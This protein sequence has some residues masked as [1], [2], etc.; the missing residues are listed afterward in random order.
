MK[1]TFKN[2]TIEADEI[3][4]EMKRALVRNYLIGQRFDSVDLNNIPVI[5][6]QEVDDLIAKEDELV[7]APLTAVEF[8]QANPAAIAFIGQT[9]EAQATAIDAMTT[10]QLKTVVKYLVVAVS[11]LIK[12][13]Y[14]T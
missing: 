1:Y 2:L 13:E 11:A 12:R 7:Q 6:V 4:L 3:T 8:F 9:P 10:A 5:D 14:L